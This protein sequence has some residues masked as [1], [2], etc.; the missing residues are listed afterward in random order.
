MRTAV[1]GPGI[2][3]R[4]QGES[5]AI[6]AEKPLCKIVPIAPNIK[7]AGNTHTGTGVDGACDSLDR[8]DSPSDTRGIWTSC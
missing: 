8:A 6:D 5:Y 1:S 7:S 2:E 4:I 3:T